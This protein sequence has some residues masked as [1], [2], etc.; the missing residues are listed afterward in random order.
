MGTVTTTTNAGPILYP[1]STHLDVYPSDKSLW[2]LSLNSAGNIELSRSINNGVSWTVAN[3]LVRAN[4]QEATIYIPAVAPEVH[5]AYRTNESSQDRVYHRIYYIN[6]NTWSSE[7]QVAFSGNGGTPGS[8]LT[9]VDLVVV[10]AN[11]QEFV[12]IAVGI[13]G[14]GTFGVILVGVVVPYGGVP[15]SAPNLFNGPTSYRQAGSGRVGP[16]LDIEN[17]G[18][19]KTAGTPHLWVTFGR[20]RINMMSCG[21]TGWGWTTPGSTYIMVDPVPAQN[22]IRGV[23]DGRRY[24]AASVNNANTSTVAV[25]ER[26]RSGT[27]S[28]TGRFTA[29]HP[30]G[31]V[32]S[33]SLAYDYSQDD[34]RVYAVGTSNNDLYFTTYDRSANTWSAWSVVTATDVLGSPPEN[35]SVKRNT[36]HNGQFDAL[37]AHTGAPNTVV[38]YAV[39]P[40]VAPLAPTWEISSGA[41]WWT[42]AN[43]T[44]DWAFNDSPNDLQTA[45]ALSR[46]I[47]TDPLMYWRASDSTWQTTE[48]KNTT[49]ATTVP[50][51]AGFVERF[52]PP[53]GNDATSVATVVG[54]SVIVSTSQKNSLRQSLQFTVSGSPVTAYAH[55]RT[56]WSPG[57]VATVGMWVYSAAGFAN[58]TT[59][60]RWLNAALGLISTS[61]AAVGAIPAATWVYRTH[62]ATAPALTANIEFGPALTSSP[63]NG[64]VIFVDDLTMTNNNGVPWG[65][66]ADPEHTYRVKTWDVTDLPSPYS[67]PLSVIPSEIVTPT[68]ATPT[69]AQVIAGDSVNV[70][71]TVAE[72]TAYRVR[73]F[74]QP[75]GLT[76]HDSGFIG[77][78]FTT[79]YAVPYTLTDNGS[80]TIGLT[81]KNNEG[82]ASAEQYQGFTTDFVEPALATLAFTPTPASGYIRVVITNPAPSGGQ[83]IVLSQELWRRPVGDTTNGTRVAVNLANNATYD[84]WRAV[85]LVSYQYRTLTRGVNGTSVYSTWQT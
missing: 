77:S 17:I 46:Q 37:I 28:T 62:T 6:S 25:W 75:S 9:G 83:P 74:Q 78:F 42:S 43:L 71:W 81:T 26:N 27:G 82:L 65:A 22:S 76:V 12:P 50:L 16:S 2:V 84:D 1:G 57:L 15:Q 56:P 5:V 66:P 68:I 45:Y 67:A 10:G 38:H 29:V 7:L 40:A 14:G 60:I 24:V 39:V 53:P 85:G 51:P 70:T 55:P 54:G 73:L 52:E 18:D 32:R 44:L 59:Q 31:V 63:A 48:Q 8:I 19:G 58:F 41:A 64:T 4:I 23:F 33:C 13:Q 49:G 21:W 47:G 35:Y 34:L 61:Q 80:W 11:G 20:T 30:A 36:F 69:P 79:S 3:T 72:Q